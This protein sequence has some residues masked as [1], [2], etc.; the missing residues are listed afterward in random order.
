VAE[1]VVTA[2]ARAAHRRLLAGRDPVRAKGLTRFFKT[3][4]GEYGEGDRFLGL[5]LADLHR[6]AREFERLSLADLRTLLKSPWHEERQL[7][8]FVLVRQFRRGDERMRAAIY[9]LYLASAPRINNWDLVDCSA[10]YIVGGYLDQRSRRPLVALARSPLVWNRRIALLATFQFIRQGDFADTLRIV[11]L[12]LDDPHDLI[13]KA[14]GWMLREVAK[15]DRRLVER[16][17]QRYAGRMPRTMLR[18][19]TE[20]FPERVRRRYLRLPRAGRKGGVMRRFKT[21]SPGSNGR[22]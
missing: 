22:A 17:L 16:F 5:H 11:S 10:G 20:R 4:V 14:A 6:L 21:H 13:H 8:L 15:R 9:R 12:L 3:G 1:R 18:Y 7:A 19:A 2:S